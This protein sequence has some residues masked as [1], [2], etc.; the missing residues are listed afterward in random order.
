MALDRHQACWSDDDD[1]DDG[2]HDHDDGG[3]DDDDE[4]DDDDDHDDDED[5][6]EAKKW[7][8]CLWPHLLRLMATQWFL[9]TVMIVSTVIISEENIWIFTVYW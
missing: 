9:W 4:D 3:D 8:N 2:N 7:G 1:D 6:N 5:D